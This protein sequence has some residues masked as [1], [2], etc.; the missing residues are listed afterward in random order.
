[1]KG[2]EKMNDEML[3]ILLAG[4][5]N[6]AGRGE[7]EA[8]DLIPVENVYA[9]NENMKWVPAIEP[10]TFDRE[11]IRGVSPGRTFAKYISKLFPD[12]KIGIIP[13]AVGG[14]PISS[15]KING[16]DIHSD[17]HPYD[18]AVI[19][20][21]NAQRYGRIIA[22]LW[23]QG[24][25]DAAQK[26]TEY[27]KDLTEVVNNFRKDLDLAPDIPFICGELGR[28]LSTETFARELINQATQNV[29]KTLPCM[30]YV[31]TENLTDKG[32]A[33]HFNTQSQKILGERYFK[34]FCRLK[35][36]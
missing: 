13:A 21:K 32:D 10:V 3:L 26:N 7:P 12:R 31:T 15:W 24:E 34:E 5:S 22:V 17:K 4:Q 29:V 28:F 1:M 8:E 33:L 19:M 18:D 11:N 14:T 2:T 20:A 23:H 36:I 35:K 16:K 25:N 6:M 9:L 27:A 30:G